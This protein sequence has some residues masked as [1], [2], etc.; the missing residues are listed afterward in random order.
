[1]QRIARC[2]GES[3]EALG[4]SLSISMGLAS[5]DVPP[6]NFPAQELISA[7]SRCLSGAH[8]AGGDTLKSIE[9]V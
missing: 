3:L 2:A 7:A 6:K 4:P 9:L 8:L 1:L 5:L